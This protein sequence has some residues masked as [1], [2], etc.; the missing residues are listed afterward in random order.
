MKDTGLHSGNTVL[1]RQDRDTFPHGAVSP[2]G[3]TD[4]KCIITKHDAFKTLMPTT[5]PQQLAVLMILSFLKETL[6]KK[7]LLA[8]VTHQIIFIL[9]QICLEKPAQC[10]TFTQLLSL[11]NCNYS[12]LFGKHIANPA[13]LQ[14][15]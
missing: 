10:V 2:G 8:K 5:S 11:N 14:P 4:I 7:T 13:F 3:K 6:C 9:K 1:E 15:K 12:C